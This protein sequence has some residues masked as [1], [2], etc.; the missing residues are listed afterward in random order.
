MGVTIWIDVEDLVVYALSNPRPSGIQRLA[1]DLYQALR[2]LDAGRGQVGFLRHDGPS[3]GFAVVAWEDVVAMFG[4]LR[5]GAVETRHAALPASTPAPGEGSGLR[6]RVRRGVYYVFPEELRRPLIRSWQ[7]QREALRQGGRALRIGARLAVQRLRRPDGNRKVLPRPLHPLAAVAQ[8]GD[9]LLALGA[10]WGDAEYARLVSRTA[11]AHGMRFGLLLYDIIPLRR[12]EW[13][14]ADLITRFRTWFESTAPVADILFSIS[15]YTA[16]DVT[17]YAAAHG[18]A[19]RGPVR[20]LPLG[21][22]FG[23]DE[24][25]PSDTALPA[26]GSYVLFV[27]TIEAR[28]NHTLLFRVWRR[29]LEEMPPELVPTLVFAGRV[30]WLVEDLLGQ[31]ANCRYLDGR[32][33]II[34]DPTDAALVALYRGCRFTLFPSLY[35]GWG[36]P[37]TESMVFGKP[38]ISSDATSLPE[39]GG[40]LAR[41][42]NPESVPDALRVIRAALE[43]EA[44]L[45]AWEARVRAEFRV[46]GWTETAAAILDALA[47]VGA[48]V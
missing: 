45:R 36:L 1:F 4:G 12:P 3:G 10:P 46:V 22:G 16:D 21:T 6:R 43:D 44:G 37:V 42:F 32:V 48:E 34:A 5:G 23:H 28:K 30:G 19:L 17:R 27:S 18:I 26:A 7:A 2:T 47:P 25:G 40:D 8:R 15:R 41:Y 9:V 38:C 29:L 39:A 20:P 14:A 33:R 24:G 13:V 35:E 11:A 31:L